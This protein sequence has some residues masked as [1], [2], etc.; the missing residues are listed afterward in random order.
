MNAIR[1]SVRVNCDANGQMQADPL[2]PPP[3]TGTPPFHS[4]PGFPSLEVHINTS[5]IGRDR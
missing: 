3:S 1:I 2:P 5:A 4:T